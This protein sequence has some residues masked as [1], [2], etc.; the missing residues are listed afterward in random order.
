MSPIVEYL[1]SV[2]VIHA[3]GAGTNETSYY[4]PL[5]VLLNRIGA[6]LK[7]SVRAVFQLADSGAGHPDFGLFTADQFVGK[8]GDFKGVQHPSRGAGE[9]KGVDEDLG[10][11][12]TSDQVS[13]YWE[14]YRQVLVTN[15][16]GFAFVT[17]GVHGQP[18]VLERLSLADSAGGFWK[19]AAESSKVKAERAEEIETFLLRCLRH[20]APIE[21]PKDL[22]WFLASYAREARGRL[23]RAPLDVLAPLR[24][25]LEETLGAQFRGEKGDRFFRATVVQTL[26][27][28]V[29]SAWTLWHR[30]NPD[31]TEEFTW[32]STPHY[33]RVPVL[34]RL[35]RELSGA[36]LKKLDLADLLNRTARLLARINRSRFFARFDVEADAIQYFYEPFL[37][38]Y[39]PKL[40][41]D[42]GVWYTPPEVVRYMVARVDT[43]LRETLGIEDGL[44]DESVVVLD[45]A[46]GTGT[47]LVEVLRQ[48]RRTLEAQGGGGLLGA[49][50]KKAATE[51]LFGFELLTAPF[52]VAHLQLGLALRAAGAPLADGERAAVYLTNALTG[53]TPQK[54]EVAPALA[55]EF[56]EEVEHARHV[57]REERILVVLG[58]PPYDGYASMAMDEERMLSD[59]YRKS[60]RADIPKPQGQGLNDLY[61]RFFRIAERQIVER[62]GRGLVCFITNNVWLDGLSHPV[63]RERM[64]DVFDRVWIDNLNGDKCRTGKTTPEGDPDPSIFSTPFNRE[65]IQPGTAVALLARTERHADTQTVAYREFWGKD[66]LKMLDA[67]ANDGT[68]AGLGM[69][70]PTY[71]TLTPEPA[72]GLPFI[73]RRMAE[74]YLDWPLLP[75][76]FPQSFPG[77]TTSCDESVVDMDLEALQERVEQYFDPSM[78]D[79]QIKSIAPRMMRETKRFDPFQTRKTLVKRGVYKDGFFRY[80][81]RPFDVRWLY[82]EPQTKLLDEKRT[83]YLPQVTLGTIAIS[84]ARKA[85]RG[86]DP[87]P[88]VTG[89]GDYVLSDPSTNYFPLHLAPDL[90]AGGGAVRPNL[91]KLAAGYLE[92]LNGTPEDLFYHALA[93]LH[94][95]EYRES[96]AGALR[97][98]WPRVPQPQSAKL[99]QA[100][101]ALGREVAT[102]LDVETPANGV[103]SGMIRPELRA[104]AVPSRADGKQLDE[105]AGDF[106][107]TVRWGYLGHVG[108]VMPGPGHLVQRRRSGGIP[109][110]LGAAVQ[111]VYLNKFAR[112]ESVPERVWSY[113]LGGYP[114]LKK[115]LSYR[116]ENVLGRPLR[117]EEIELF[118]G[119]A[120]R[121]AALL[122]LESE[123]DANYAA[124][125][126]AS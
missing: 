6:G 51:R 82:W 72:L 22:A 31:R 21:T 114:V 98:D 9:V 126:G 77:V 94:A 39:D 110:E 123:L 103:T 15:L 24:E 69:E 52:V 46:C 113:T 36:T 12:A 41:K 58:N 107:V 59:A 33:L 11:L 53:W 120:R 97:Q 70:T 27:Y 14:T 124:V 61:V 84:I 60:E 1:Q 37:E 34:D 104:V 119:I 32:H 108:Q 95:P 74:A 118:A 105:S 91:S 115:W 65:G 10:S 89:F 102:L 18:I 40:R 55:T 86:W 49:K 83:E 96:N 106:A 62:T 111:D 30:E 93:V 87:P 92:D 28:G 47:F 100:S 45:P 80:C 35:F 48:I 109:K 25:A 125:V 116:T 67:L 64:L 5:E 17:E 43:E 42:L 78:S 81:Y 19:L 20:A 85:R 3:T 57:K 117:L 44:A 99:L 121:I 50:L 90:G 101:A 71:A 13:R 16:R 63:M 26:F 68:L 56:R 38:A 8:G 7:P 75:D 73:P 54:D 122:L 4:G 66:K 2:N 76:L 29:F 23:D 112:W 79:E 88:V